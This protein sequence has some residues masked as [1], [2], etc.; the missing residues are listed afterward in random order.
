MYKINYDLQGKPINIKREDGAYIPFD[1]LNRDFRKFLEWNK[2]QKPPLDYETPIA[3]EP[4]APV[5]TL[6]E[7]IA[8]EVAKQL[9]GK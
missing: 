4:P 8:K 1:L 2:T 5:E 3:V 7:K 9:K 6:E